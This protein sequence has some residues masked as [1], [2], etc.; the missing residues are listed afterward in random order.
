MKKFVLGTLTGIV[1]T[2]VF[3]KF[4]SPCIA[5][6]V[7]AFKQKVADKVKELEAA[8]AGKAAEHAE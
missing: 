7:E 2:V 1:A 4:V 3:R 5:P 8:Q 6:Q